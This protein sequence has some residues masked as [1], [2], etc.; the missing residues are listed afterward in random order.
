M[1]SCE[2]MDFSEESIKEQILIRLNQNYPVSNPVNKPINQ[3]GFQT[4]NNESDTKEKIIQDKKL[5]NEI[6]SLVLGTQY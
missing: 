1:Y 4:R 2:D 3:A 5:N 6:A